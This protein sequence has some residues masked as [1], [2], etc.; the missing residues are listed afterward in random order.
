MYDKIS[1]KY[2]ERINN[3]LKSV[4]DNLTYRDYIPFTTELAVTPQPVSFDNRLKLDYHPVHENEL[5]GYDWANGWFHF[6]ATVPENFAGKELCLRIHTGSEMLLFDDEGVPIYGLTGFSIFDQLYCKERFVIPRRFKAGEK[7]EFWMQSVAHSLYG[8]PLPNPENL[9]EINASS[10]CGTRLLKHMRLCIFD[11]EMWGMLLDMRMLAGIMNTY[12]L[13]D[14]RGRR[15]LKILTDALNLFNYDTS[16]AAEV[17]QMLKEKAFSFPASSSAPAAWATGHGHLDIGWLWPVPIATGKAAR[18]FSSQIALLEKY[19]EYI[20]GA[21][22]AYLYRIIKQ[23][24]PELYAKIKQ[25]VADG[26][27]EVQGGMYVEADCNMTSGESLIRQFLHGKNFFR[28]EFGVDVN[29]LWIPDVFGYSANLPQISLKAG[30]RYFVTQKLS[31]NRFTFIPYHTFNWCGVDGS[32]LLGHFP[33]ENTYAAFASSEQRIEA[34]NRFAEAGQCDSFISLY[35][36]GDGGGGPSEDFVEN[37]LR[38]QDLDGCPKTVF[39]RADKFFE[40]LSAIGDQLPVWKGELYFENH[41]GTLTSQSRT[42]RGNRKSEQLLT[43]VE[44]LCSA[45]DCSKYPQKEL[46]ELWKMVLLNQFHDILPGSSI[47]E[48]YEQTEKD[49][50]EIEKRGKSLAAAAAGELFEISPEC[51]TAVNSLSVSYR[52]PLK[53]PESWQNSSV[54][55][56][57]GRPLPCQQEKDGIYC[58]VE[59]SPDSFTTLKRTGIPATQV[60]ALDEPV[61]ENELIR[62]QF[63]PTG[64]L[65][66]AFDKER[67][68]EVMAAPGNILSLYHDR[69]MQYEAWDLENYYPE[70]R[71][72]QEIAA[73][74]FSGFTGPVRSGLDF[75]FKFGQ[76]TLHQRVILRPD[77]RKLDFETTVDFQ[78]SRM[79]LRTAFP[80]NVFTPEAA[81]DIQYAFIK[82]STCSNTLNEQAQIECCGQR[83]ADISDGNG[84][85]ALLND[86]KYGYRIKD[87][88]LDL[89]L[90]RSPRYPDP[91]ADLGIH[92]FT[93]SFLPHNG[94]LTGS[95]VQAESAALNREPMIFDGLAAGKSQP[96]CRRISG[97]GVSLE[98]I[99]KA[100]KSDDIIIRVVETAGKNSC[101]V[102]QYSPEIRE[103]FECDIM[104]WN[105]LHPKKLDGGKQEIALKAFEIKTFIAKK[106]Q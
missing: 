17:R 106:W 44:F 61:L 39:G 53:M 13:K 43:A 2:Q 57:S 59:L 97:N 85:V 26:R 99:K 52:S 45:L 28:D 66:S 98:V 63:S 86:C 91:Q 96:V 35:G 20:F 30:C 68:C 101:G 51:A 19:P 56:I 16:K 48:V 41:Y 103:V 11:R 76:S 4:R 10:G 89:A 5:W 95:N 83:F 73:E 22:Q 55:D 94:D 23:N 81:F 9:S 18:T 58:L 33:P 49:Y 7:V 3:F 42:K 79:M 90:L 65:L 104:E 6:T 71:L 46:D 67:G 105:I 15:M 74:S 37:N 38:Q 32:K 80:V 29:T 78:E 60:T 36:I 54:S 100:E 12:G 1:Q 93:Y 64:Q 77:S 24:Y 70:D 21:S 87:N 92:R 27:W 47:R 88:I 75:N 8:C 50:A 25:A 72:Q 34:M 14:F 31:Q 102:L 62:Y 69:P 82:R 84:G 40:N